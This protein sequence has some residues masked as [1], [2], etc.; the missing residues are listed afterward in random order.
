MSLKSMTAL[1]AIVALATGGNNDDLAKLAGT[2]VSVNN[3]LLK[4]ALDRKMAK[5]Q[6]QA[7]EEAAE[8]ILSIIKESGSIIGTY[9]SRIRALRREE[10]VL[11]KK[12]K[13][14]KRAI[15]YGNETGNW[16]PLGIATGFISEHSIR[17]EVGKKATKI[18]DDWV[19]S[20]SAEEQAIEE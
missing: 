11:L 14:L 17:E 9:V 18:P 19:A 20:K 3:P 1:Q 7:A 4:A 6:E 2:A 8:S 10:K 5:A 16:L 15:D 13:D 12:I